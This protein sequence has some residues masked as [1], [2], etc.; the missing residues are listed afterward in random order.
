VTGHPEKTITYPG[1]HELAYLHPDLFTPDP[2]IRQRYIPGDQPYFLIRFAKLG[3]HHDTHAKGISDAI[4]RKLIALLEPHGRVFITS[5]RPLPPEFEPYRLNIH[6]IDIHH[7]MAYSLLFIGDSQTMSAESGVLGVPFIRF[8]AF[9]GKIGYLVELEEKYQL[10]VSIHPDNEE[11]LY[12]Q[13]TTWLP[14]LGDR[15]HWE[16]KR[17]RLLNDKIEVASFMT[18]LIESGKW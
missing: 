16:A 1:N 6:P 8:N 11:A 5:E 13:V 7:I 17:Q 12:R 3:A 18:R 10:G 4:A 9:A 15:L 14:L 2:V